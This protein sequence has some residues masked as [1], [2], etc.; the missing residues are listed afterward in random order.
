MKKNIFKHYK[1]SI[2]VL[3]SVFVSLFGIITFFLGGYSQK[4]DMYIFH[5]K[6]LS[7]KLFINEIRI[8]DSIVSLENY[9]YKTSKYNRKKSKIMIS[10]NENYAIRKSKIDNL[11]LSFENND[12][13]EKNIIVEKNG[14]IINSIKIKKHSNNVYIDNTST[15]SIIIESIS[16]LKTIEIILLI[17]LFLLLNIVVYLSLLYIYNFIVNLSNNKFKIIK[18]IFSIALLFLINLLYIIPLMQFSKFLSILPMIISLILITIFFKTNGCAKLH[19]YYLIVAMFVGVLFLFVLAPLH[20]PDEPSHV[21]KAYQNSLAFQNNN[22][23][24]K[25]NTYARLPKEMNKFIIKY[26]DQVLNYDYRLQ[27]R[28]YTYDLFKINNYKDLSNTYTWYSLKYTS[29]VAYIPGTIISLI[30]RITKMPMLLFYYF[31]KLFNYI[32]STLMCYFALKIVPKFKKVF[33]IVP[34]LP[35]FI[36]QSFGFNV[37][38]LTNSTFILL[39]A[40]IIKSIYCI[41]EM[42]KRD[43]L[44]MI[45]LA[46]LLGFCKFGY[47]PIALLFLL[48][49]LNNNN[50]NIS[51][52]NRKIYIAIIILVTFLTPIFVTCINN[53]IASNVHSTH[54]SER[55]LIPVSALYTNPRMI[56][57]MIFETFKIRLDLDFFRGFVTGFGCSTI[58]ANSLILFISMVFLMIVILCKDDYNSTLSIKKRIVFFISFVAMCGL[59]YGAMLFGWSEFGSTSI[60]GLQPRYFIPPVM[61]LYILLQNNIIIVNF[62]DKKQFYTLSM[63]IINFLALITII[64]NIYI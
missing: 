25:D 40:F 24:S 59:I 56:L 7:N 22:E 39:L 34:L 64:E 23:I 4:S 47:F 29:S 53:F 30:A 41:D 51:S 46:L 12:N 37:D 42:C 21:I 32:I 54:I 60:D 19:Q 58:W 10:S 55:N 17:I 26:G 50:N 38:W 45:V 28:T 35:I 44:I 8:S 62:D 36:Q 31:S 15:I 14:K 57:S 11:K 6:S 1:K 52:K 43:Y 3:I 33:F 5:T 27:A 18:F 61:L 48:M 2:F 16:N 63:I 49:P 9:Q 13:I 20:V